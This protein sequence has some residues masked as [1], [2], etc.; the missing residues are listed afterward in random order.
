[1]LWKRRPES[2][3]WLHERKGERD[4]LK[5]WGAVKKSIEWRGNTKTCWK[6]RERVMRKRLKNKEV[7]VLEMKKR[8]KRK[9][10]AHYAKEDLK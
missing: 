2:D 3:R 9:H 6:A 10:V 1:M 5:D 8:N 4:R 7:A